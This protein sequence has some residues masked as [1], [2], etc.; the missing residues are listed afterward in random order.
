MAQVAVFTPL[1]RLL[2]LLILPMP[3]S[4]SVPLPD[5]LTHNRWF[6]GLH[7]THQAMLLKATHSTVLRDGQLAI[8]QGASLRKRGDGLMVLHSGLLKISSK[9]AAG[10][11]AVLGFIQPG[12]WFGE[13][14]MLDGQHRERDV[15]SIGVSEV[16]VVEAETFNR[17]MQDTNFHQ[18]LVDLQSARTRLL[19]SLVEDFSLRSARARAARRLL[20]LACDDDTRSEP[21]RKVLIVSHEALASMLGMTRQTLALQLKALTEAGAII[22][23]YGRI[24][25]TS[26]P[27]LVAEAAG[28]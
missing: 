27:L 13:L 23:G 28:A 4:L 16:L 24:V 17:L 12:Q 6:M 21:H 9:N 3:T 2:A 20:M 22:Q 5:A 1:C 26:I 8:T 11:E 10:S 15:R 25:V 14:S 18:Q 19:L 7:T